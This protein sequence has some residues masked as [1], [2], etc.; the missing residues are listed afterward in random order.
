MRLWSLH[1]KYLDCKGLLAL[2]REGL[3]A[4]KVLEGRTMGYRNHPQLE[5]FYGSKDPISLMNS[6]LCYVLKES[7][8][9]SYNFD[10]HKIERRPAAARIPVTT[11]QLEHEFESLKARVSKR[12]PGWLETLNK[13][14][15]PEPSPLFYPVPGKPE[16]WEK[17]K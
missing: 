9:R 4:K 14:K 13:T 17:I 7:E 10:K 6:Y 5:R 1:P 3:L 15:T 2:W 12:D 16:S 11:G 8:K